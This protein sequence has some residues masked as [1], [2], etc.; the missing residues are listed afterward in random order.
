MTLE[1][2]TL[3]VLTSD[4]TLYH[5]NVTTTRDTIRLVIVDSM[6]LQ[7]LNPSASKVRALCGFSAVREYKSDDRPFIS[8]VLTLHYL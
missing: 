6:S 1:G 4:N 3:L 2:S 5:Y 8:R 7:G